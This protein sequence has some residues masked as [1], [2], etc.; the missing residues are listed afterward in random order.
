MKLKIILFLIISLPF[1]K[2][3]GSGSVI[4]NGGDPIFY[5]LE[6]TRNSFVSTVKNVVLLQKEKDLFCKNNELT[7]NQI[8]FCR[9]LFFGVANQ[10]LSL[11]QGLNKTQFVLREEPLLV[12]GPD[13]KPMPVAARTTLGAEGVIEFHRES[14]KLMSPAQIL[15]LIAHE[16]VHKVKFRNSYITDNEV[17]PPFSSGRE[18]IDLF[19]SSIVDSAKRNGKIGRQYSLRDSFECKVTVGSTYF[20]VRTST[21]RFFLTENLMSYETSLSRNP[22]D[23]ALYIPESPSSNLVFRVQ[24]TE[25]ANC[26]DEA[27][28]SSDRKTELEIIRISESRR[29]HKIFNEEIIESK[30]MPAFNPICDKNFSEFSLTHADKTFSCRHYGTEGSTT[31]NQLSNLNFLTRGELITF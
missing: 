29:N 24:I 6:A 27:R 19:A 12:S 20:G 10:L 21:P 8:E 13:G 9:D 18:L 2:S 4:G 26:S 17:I 31:S 15:F 30:I 14:I 22:T 16:F 23:S 3:H 5:F 7:N 11:N 1:L 28:Y 25:P